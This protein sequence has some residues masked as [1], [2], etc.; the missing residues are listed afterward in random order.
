MIKMTIVFLYFMKGYNC[1]ISKGYHKALGACMGS[2]MVAPLGGVSVQTLTHFPRGNLA[3]KSQTT[4]SNA[5]P[6]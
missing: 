2:V 6:Q 3:G 5:F 1:N 4:F